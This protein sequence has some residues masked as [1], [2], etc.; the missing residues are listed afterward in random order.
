MI[1]IALL[2]GFLVQ[3][4]AAAPTQARP[5]EAVAVRGEAEL[6][7]AAAYSSA[8][9]RA[10]EHLRDRWR[11]R[12]ERVVE[13]QRPFWMPAVFGELTAGRWLADLPIERAM[14]VVDRED[15][16]RQHE[17]GASWQTTLWVAEDPRLAASLEQ[18]LRRDL[19]RTQ[20]EVLWKS[21][22]TVMFWSM[23]AFGLGWLDRLSRGYMT[24]RLMAIGLLLGGGVPVVAFLL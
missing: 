20:T 21:G 12:A 23:L 6:T 7:Q 9:T 15:Q 18:R 10:E 22:G 1:A 24:R 17:F 19:K 4:P 14:A 3:D 5:Q 8:R 16:E 11:E 2:L 13:T